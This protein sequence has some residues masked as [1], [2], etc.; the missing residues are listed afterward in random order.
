LLTHRKI[1][2]EVTDAAVV[3][4]SIAILTPLS[5]RHRSNVS[6]FSVQIHNHPPIITLLMSDRVIVRHRTGEDRIRQA[7]RQWPGP[8]YLSE[9]PDQAIVEAL[10]LIGAE[11][12]PEPNTDPLRAFDP[13]NA[14]RQLWAEQAR[15]GRLMC[16]SADCR[17]A[18]G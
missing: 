10:D 2:P 18:E 7:Q 12:L 6:T 9:Y 3:Q 14:R 4:Q 16:E 17:K 13:A 8:S 5:Y 11:P 15:I 1:R